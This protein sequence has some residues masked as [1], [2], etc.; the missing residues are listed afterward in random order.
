MRLVKLEELIEGD[1][2][3]ENIFTETGDVL[4]N[5]R[6]A[7]REEYRGYLQAAGIHSLF[8]EDEVSK[9]IQPKSLLPKQVKQT[10]LIDI[11]QVFTRMKNTLTIDQ[12][13]INKITQMLIEE[14]SKEEMVMEL[15]DLR[16][17]RLTVYEHSIAVALMCSV[18]CKRLDI[19]EDLVPKIVSGA[20]L[21][22]I[23]KKRLPIDLL[24]KKELTLQER[25]LMRSHI[26][27][28][29]NIIK[30]EVEISPLTKLIV[31][32]HHEREDGS[33]YPF[34]KAGEL[35]IGVKVVSVC[36]Y[37]HNLI[38]DGISM[39]QIIS[40]S[41]GEGFDENIRKAVE[42]IVAFYP[43]G[44]LVKLT[45]GETA[46]VEKNFIVDLSRPFVRVVNEGEVLERTNIRFNLQE[47][48]NIEIEGRIN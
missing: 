23:G 34:G 17:N 40:R 21:H 26:N 12:R 24:N 45:T 37:F 25:Q 47:E 20:L 1:T 14:I 39:D 13:E 33:G 32:C 2:I 6:D 19:K 18:V 27:K 10:I 30:D 48:P 46:I 31:L 42:S 35:H 4:I 7:F 11:E 16:A 9:G 5:A 29:Y 41:K 38:M 43:V 3:A 15:I 28:G 44:T 8:I 36:D 22:D